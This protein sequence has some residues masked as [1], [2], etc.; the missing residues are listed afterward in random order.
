MNDPASSETAPRCAARMFLDGCTRTGS[1]SDGMCLMH[2]NDEK[3]DKE[4]W[5]T[6]ERQLA[7]SDLDFSGYVFPSHT[8]FQN[9]TFSSKTYFLGATFPGNVS[10]WRATFSDEAVFS[11]ATF[12][13]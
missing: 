10:F 6:F 8:S 9:A 11:G 13:G 7:D 1:H 12:P 2:S 5:L 4:F 3:D